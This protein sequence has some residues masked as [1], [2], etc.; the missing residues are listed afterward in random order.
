MAVRRQPEQ[1]APPVQRFRIRYAKRGRA[2]FTSHRDFARAFERA[3]RRAGVPMAFSSG[4]SPH[5]RVSYA[6]AT[7]TGVA[8]EAEYLEIGVAARCDPERLRE[9][10]D[11][12][13]PAGLD[14]VEVVEAGGGGLADR[15]QVAEWSVDLGPAWRGDLDL[16]VARFGAAAAVVTSRQTKNGP[17][18][19]DSRPATLLLETTG[20]R[21][22]RMVI[23]HDTPQVR[24]EDVVRGLAGLVAEEVDLAPVRFTRM[25]QGPWDGE[26]VGD[27]L[28]EPA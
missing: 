15:L 7:S 9:A 28:A 21:S 16:A 14:I 2:R 20:P 11:A 10:L 23:R 13:L 1:Q 27:P 26:R 5:P 25:A 17:R 4:F 19:F 22:L 8:S 18:D 12:A 3:L 6:N 24:P